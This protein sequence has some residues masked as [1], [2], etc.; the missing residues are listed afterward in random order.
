MTAPQFAPT[1]EDL[2]A[3]RAQILAGNGRRGASQT[4]SSRL[5]REQATSRCSLPIFGSFIYSKIF[6]I[7]SGLFALVGIVFSIASKPLAP[8]LCA[9]SMIFS[10][11]NLANI[12]LSY[13][14]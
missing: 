9:I 6:G 14:R 11:A 7:L 8:K 13:R 10:I 1:Q 4:L 2:L 12:A 5:R 3:K